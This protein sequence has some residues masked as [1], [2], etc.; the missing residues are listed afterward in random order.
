[1][2]VVLLV[3]HVVTMGNGPPARTDHQ[4]D[5]SWMVLNRR[6]VPLELYNCCIHCDHDVYND[7][8]RQSG[9]LP[10]VGM[11]VSFGMHT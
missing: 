4:Y 9:P 11:K 3:V 10:S 2:L 8:H 7:L 1:M 6:S 5:G